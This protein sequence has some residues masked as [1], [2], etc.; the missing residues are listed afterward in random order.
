MDSSSPGPAPSSADRP[1]ERDAGPHVNPGRWFVSPWNFADATVAS[2]TPPSRV[3]FHDTTLRDG[4]QQ[5]GIAFTREDKVAIAKKLAHAKVDRIEAGMAAVSPE[6]EAAI[7]DIVQLNL[8]PDV[9]AFSRCMVADVEMAKQCEVSGIV[10][11]IPSSQ[12]MVKYAYGWDL[13]RAV[14]LSIEATLAAHDAGLRTTFFTI[15]ASRAEMEWYLDLIE[16]VATEG[17]MDSLTLVDTLGVVNSHAIPVWVKK[18]RERLPEVVLETHMHN[19]FGLATA[20][21]L[22]AVASGCSVVHTTVAGLGERAGN[23]PMEETALALRM[24]Y[25]IDHGIDTTT[26]GELNSL[27]R[28]RS[29]QA[30]QTNRPVTGERLYEI[31][32]GII[33]G[34]YNN[35]I[36]DRPL[37]LFPYHWS[38]VGQAPARLVYGKGS[39]LPSLDGIEGAGLDQPDD[40]RRAILLQLKYRAL[41]TK[42]LISE[43]ELGE[44][45]R[46]AHDDLRPSG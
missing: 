45:V 13:D 22:A 28:E 1:E 15:D 26:F 41:E 18:V 30:V 42:R 7:K 29:R 31:E 24:L 14:K 44:I 16:R 38:E 25:G 34:W 35:C 46:A 10:V 27:V 37:E 8:G 11:E 6:D 17:H 23:A 20:N 3:E 12:H 32:S 33:A 19:D 39:G 40:L 2:L 36:A 4:E 21:T 43:E 9:Y 5:A